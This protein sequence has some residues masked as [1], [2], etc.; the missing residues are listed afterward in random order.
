MSTCL[1]G[2]FEELPP[3]TV[4]LPVYNERY[5]VERL[6]E[7]IIKLEYPKELLQIQVLDDSTDETHPFTE[8]LV[9][10]VS[11][12]GIPDRISPSDKSARIQS[13]GV[14]GR[15]AN[16]H[17]RVRRDFRRRLRSACR[18]STADD[19]SLRRSKSGRG[20]DALE[21]SESRATIS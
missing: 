21:L 11:R 14:A 5:V 9:E 6:I 15:I 18:F 17:G 1:L 20:A 13:G 7:E 4:Q 10:P 8:A 3:V 19:P 12:S 16:G 2:Q